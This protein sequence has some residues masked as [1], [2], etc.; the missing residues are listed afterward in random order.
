MTGGFEFGPL[1]SA[2]AGVLVLVGTVIGVILVAVRAKPGELMA[3][4]TKLRQEVRDVDKSLS[5]LRDAF[6]N[7]RA[8]QAKKAEEHE[9]QRR[10]DRRK[11]A[12][13]AD[14]VNTMW[15]CLNVL[16]RM[17]HDTGQQV[18]EWPESIRKIMKTARDQA[19][20]ST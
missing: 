14:G 16:T 20:D 18:P 3:D 12:V 13:L 6:D 4:N 15:E 11:I 5:E 17:L 10:A 2:L 1:L 8:E 7:Y 19:Q 9:D